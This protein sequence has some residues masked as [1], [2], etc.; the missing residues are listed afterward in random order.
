M[1]SSLEKWQATTVVL[2]VVV[3]VAVLAGLG[4]IDGE[5]AAAGLVGLGNLVLGAGAVA[6]G[7]R[8]GSKASEDGS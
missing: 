8:Q 6:H 4:V 7:V 1:R 3:S 5:T 2:V